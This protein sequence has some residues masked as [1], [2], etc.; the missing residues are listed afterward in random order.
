MVCYELKI[1]KLLVLVMLRLARTSASFASEASERK[2]LFIF[3]PPGVGKGTYAK[4]LQKDLQLN[5]ISTGD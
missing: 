3:G 5:H 2:I 4:M 1:I